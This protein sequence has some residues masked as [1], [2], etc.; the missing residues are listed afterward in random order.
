LFLPHSGYRQLREEVAAC[1]AF[2]LWEACEL[3]AGKHALP[4][5]FIFDRKRDGRF[6]ARLVAG[7]HRQQQGLDLQETFASVC[8][9]GT[10]H[11]I[12]AVAACEDLVLRQIDVQTWVLHAPIQEEVYVR[13][14]AGASHLAGGNSCTVDGP[15][16]NPLEDIMAH[17]G[18]TLH[19]RARHSMVAIVSQPDSSVRAA[20]ANRVVGQGCYAQPVLHGGAKLSISAPELAP[21]AGL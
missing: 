10:M 9:Y 11:I 21:W 14:R 18:L 16:Q 7:G 13:P 19:R 12:L 17:R 6:K 2:N 4:S 1:L 15:A 8:A 5:H 20:D 3:H